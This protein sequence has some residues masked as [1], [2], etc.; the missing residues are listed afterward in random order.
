MAYLQA[1]DSLWVFS[2]CIVAKLLRVTNALLNRN[3]AEH[4]WAF[5]RSPLMQQASAVELFHRRIW[6]LHKR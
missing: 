5:F 4:V 2:L 3:M 6:H 1:R